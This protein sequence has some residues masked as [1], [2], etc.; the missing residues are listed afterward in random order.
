[1]E[2]KILDFTFHQQKIT[3]VGEFSDIINYDIRVLNK[4]KED[5]SYYLPAVSEVKDAFNS[6]SLRVQ[7]HPYKNIY[8]TGGS[9]H[10]GIVK[11]WN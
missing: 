2:D 4:L 10:D 8:A 1:V 3:A 9:L 11:V 5:G 7:R 6:M